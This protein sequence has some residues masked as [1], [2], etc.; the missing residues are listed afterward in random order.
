MLVVCCGLCFWL[1]FVRVVVFILALYLVVGVL[2]LID[3]WY[4]LFVGLV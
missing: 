3:W 1:L 2:G 4:T